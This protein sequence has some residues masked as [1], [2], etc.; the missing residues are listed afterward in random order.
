MKNLLAT[1]V[2]IVL[3]F[4]LFTCNDKYTICEQSKDVHLKGVFFSKSGNIF[5]ETTVNSL[6]IN[7]L[8]SSSFIYKNQPDLSSFIFGL[9]SLADSAKYVIKIDNA[10][11]ADT[12]TLYY[13]SASFSLSS[14]CG[15]II[16]HE[17]VDVKTTSNTLD[18][19]KINVAKI[20]N[21]NS[22]N[23]KLFF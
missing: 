2:I 20:D 23:L 3:L 9:Q 12:V 7:I 14:A 22:M 17:L 16:I 21:T 4:T 11:Q 10:L 5:T 8:D 13:T 15:S 19:V 18:S 6:S 1:T